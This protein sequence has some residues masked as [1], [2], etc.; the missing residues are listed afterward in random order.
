M[1]NPVTAHILFNSIIK[2]HKSIVQDT[3]SSSLARM[4]TKLCRKNGIKIINIV[5]KDEY[6]NEFD[7]T[8]NSNSTNF[9]DNLS[10]AI[11]DEPSPSLYITYQ[12]GNF[13][14]RIF[15]RLPNNSTMCCCGN[16][17]SELLSGYSSTDFIF[18]GKTII[19]FQVINYMAEM[20]EEEKQVVYQNIIEDFSVAYS[21]NVNSD[22]NALENSIYFTRISK[23]FSMQQFDEARKFYDS[24]MSKGK[25]ILKP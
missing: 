22:G 18:K 20:T 10:K 9:W 7:I 19:G 13:P 2:K 23:E 14:S 12:G 4:I 6:V 3:S 5:R 8:F 24:N 15:D 11:K 25:I 21:N 16:I 1:A 17:N